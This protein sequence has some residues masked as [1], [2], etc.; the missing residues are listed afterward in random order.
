MVHNTVAPPEPA[1]IGDPNNDSTLHVAVD[2]EV[3]SQDLKDMIANC[4]NYYPDD[5]PTFEDMLEQIEEATKGSFD[6]SVG[7][8]DGSPALEI[9]NANMPMFVDEF[10]PRFSKR[11]DTEL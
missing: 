4:L 11:P 2:A 6:R 5:R 7:M 9:Q 8:K 3:W 1:W 10:Y